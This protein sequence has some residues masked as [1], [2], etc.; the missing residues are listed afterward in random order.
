MMS[1]TK[2]C[3]IAIFFFVLGFMTV[4]NM[5]KADDVI[6]CYPNAEFMKV[7]DEKALVTLYNGVIGNKMHEVMMTK[8]RH[9]YIV[10]YDKVTDGNAMAAKQYCVTG[11]LNDVTFNDS[12]IEF[13]S[14]LLDKYKGQKT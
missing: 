4:H 5:A 1:R 3:L 11:I 10:E 13:L 12:A 9:M 6:K 14:Q 2:E 8:D 7:I